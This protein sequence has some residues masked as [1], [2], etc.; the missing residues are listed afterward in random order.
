MSCTLY[1][2]ACDNDYQKVVR[3]RTDTSARMGKELE[4]EQPIGLPNLAG[5]KGW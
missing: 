4:Q 5:T 3:A 2:Q 1:K